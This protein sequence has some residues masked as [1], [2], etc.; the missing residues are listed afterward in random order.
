MITKIKKIQNFGIYKDCDF[1]NVNRFRKYNLIY[2]WNGSGKSTLSRLFGLISGRGVTETHDGFKASV[3]INGEEYNQNQFPVST[4]SIMVFNSDFIEENIN[5]NGVLK[6][7]LLFDEKNIEDVERYNSLKKELRGSEGYVG[8]SD[9][10]KTKEKDLL[11]AKNARNDT[12]TSIGRFVKERFISLGVNDRYYLNYNKNN[13]L[14]F[15]DG[16]NPVSESDL[17]EDCELND[18]IKSVIPTQKDVIKKKVYIP[19]KDAVRRGMQKTNELI[20]MAITSKVIEDLKNDPELSS[21]VKEGLNLHRLR[22][23]NTCAF[24]GSNISNA[25][26]AVLDGHFNDALNKLSSDIDALINGWESLK[27]NSSEIL[28]NA[29]EFYDEYSESI[30]SENYK[31]E[32]SSRLINKEIDTYIELLREKQRNPF[33]GGDHKIEEEYIIE[34]IDGV[35]LIKDKIDQCIDNHNNKV[36]NLDDVTNEARLRLERH[37]IQEQIT[38]NKYNDKVGSIQKLENT[39]EEMQKEYSEKEAVFDQLEKSISNENLGADEFNE[40]LEKF[41][42]YSELTIKFDENEKGYKIFRNGKEEAKNLS[43]GERTAIAFIYFIIKLKENGHKMEDFIL[44]IDDPISSFDSNKLFSACAYM[45]SECDDAKQLFVL[46]H[47]YNFF[48]QVFAWF[49]GKHTKIESSGKRKGKDKKVLNY[50][51][52][53]VENEFKDGVRIARLCNGGEYLRQATEYDYIFYKVYSWRNKTLSREEMIFCGN[54][55]RK[56]VESFLSFKFPKYR[57]NLKELMEQALPGQDNDIARDRMYRFINI[58]SHENRI[59]VHEE[60]DTDVLGANSKTVIRDILGMIKKLDDVH[61]SAMVENAEKE[62]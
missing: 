48:S 20:N 25:R 43:E 56:L 47:N 23:K 59:N 41:L 35:T 24:C 32:D 4:E 15:I 16:S 58:Y 49:K 19:S 33:K 34:L 60:L 53:R 61:Y 7:I 52:Y 18:L 8:L 3:C 39:L 10:I 13:V 11:G 46:T 38:C 40:K 9:K 30:K 36:V 28:I 37:Y 51:I 62:W 22:G 2:G 42:G 6:S 27:I 55:A 29:S 26:M 21:W 5:W 12:L 31:F 17:I 45:R 14:S 44:V 57:A 1:S 50:S 54:V